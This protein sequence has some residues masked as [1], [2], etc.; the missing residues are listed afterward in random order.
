MDE[1]LLMN[2][3]LFNQKKKRESQAYMLRA[4]SL[5]FSSLD[6]WTLLWLEIGYGLTTH[7]GEKLR[8]PTRLQPM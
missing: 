6:P 5:S 8:I 3:K 1:V 7:K 4:M 2:R